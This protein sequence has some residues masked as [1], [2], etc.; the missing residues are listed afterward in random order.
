M[1]LGEGF[2]A[3]SI[4]FRNTAGAEKHQ[5]VALRVQSDRS[6]FLNCRMEG[7]QDTLYAQTHRQFYRSCRLHFRRRRHHF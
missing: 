3:Q 5:A 2:M 1:A 6:I 4:G 7:Y